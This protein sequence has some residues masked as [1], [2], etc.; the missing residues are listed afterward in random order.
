ML[1]NKD[2]QKGM[3]WDHNLWFVSRKE[4]EIVKRIYN[5]KDHKWG[6]LEDH[7]LGLLII[8]IK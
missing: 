5:I 1:Q 4:V 8:I 7:N 6:I 2:R 3:L